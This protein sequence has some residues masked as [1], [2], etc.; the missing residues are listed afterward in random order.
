VSQAN[1]KIVKRGVEEFIATGQL[2]DQTAADFIWDVTTLR[3]WPDQPLFHGVDGFAEFMSAWRDAYDDWSL[4][5]K[6]VLD[7]GGDKVVGDL[8]QKGRLRESDAWVELRM[9]VVY[10]VENGQVQRAQA[11]MTVEEALEAVGLAK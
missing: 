8:L 10:T 4:D 3:G 2:S 7:A 1:V 9:G 11:Y 6:Q 5:L